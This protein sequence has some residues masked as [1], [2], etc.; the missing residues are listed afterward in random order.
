MGHPVLRPDCNPPPSSQEREA[1]S[2]K[3][4]GISDPSRRSSSVQNTYMHFQRKRREREV[5]GP[6]LCPG[7]RTV[8]QMG[9]AGVRKKRAKE[10][11]VTEPTPEGLTATEPSQHPWYLRA[12]TQTLWSFLPYPSHCHH[13]DVWG[14]PCHASHCRDPGHC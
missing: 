11:K 10:Q 6:L 2:K 13:D 9:H 1:S 8:V 4:N 7:E 12:E 14:V 5:S 3:A